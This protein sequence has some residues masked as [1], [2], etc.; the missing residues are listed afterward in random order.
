MRHTDASVADSPSAPG[1]DERLRAVLD[2]LRSIADTADPNWRPKTGDA[3]AIVNG[4][5]EAL[6]DLLNDSPKAAAVLEMLRDLTITDDA[7]I[8]AANAPRRLGEVLGRLE[9]APSTVADLTKL[10]PQLTQHLGFDRAIFSRVLD[11]VWT[12]EVVFVVDDPKWAEEIN[13]A[14]QDAP[15]QFVPGLH[16]T[17]I[18]RRREAMIVTDVQQDS[19]VHRPIAD[20]SRSNS[21]VAAPITSGSRVVGLLHADCYVQGRDPDVVDC[22]ALV[23]YAKGLQLALS[24]ARLA[25]QLQAVGSQLNRLA[26]DC[27]DGAAAVHEFSFG[28][29]HPENPGDFTRA[30]R[31]TQTALRGVRDLLTAREAQ[32]LELMAEGLSNSRIAEQLVISEGTVKQHV[33][34]ILRKLGAGNRVEAVS[35]LYQSDGA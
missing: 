26:N 23:A 5:W 22:E 10:G 30:L 33:K 32:I 13:R 19:R 28:Q 35:M 4:A 31:V 16:E 14:G 1:D 7:L 29:S 18:V 20:A 11:G 12:S 6:A 15:Q 8:R 24:R 25:E 17:E 9:S 27:Q 3:R 21:Y 34:H 2:G